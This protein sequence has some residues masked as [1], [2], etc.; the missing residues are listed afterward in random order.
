MTT[1]DQTMKSFTN[2]KIDPRLCSY[3]L[4][5]KIRRTIKK[6][7]EV[8]AEDNDQLKYSINELRKAVD[9]ED[10]NKQLI[11]YDTLSSIHKYLQ[12]IDSNYDLF[13]Y[14]FLDECKVILP[15]SRKNKELEE[16][17]IEL[18]CKQSVKDYKSMTTS[19]GGIS[20]DKESASS[21]S[22]GYEFRQMRPTLIAVFNAFLTIGGT[23]I[24]V[25]KAVEYSLPEPHISTQVLS[26]L[27]GAMIV[28]VAEMYF[29]VRII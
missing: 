22:L 1:D 23:F 13:F 19:M 15:Q 6:A 16:R 3:R 26:G 9:T 5:N 27:F 17:L 14:Q 4:G 2:N 11:T 24:F 12:R 8:D 7:I 21:F 20:S 18:N 29:L 28:A 25:Y 10:D